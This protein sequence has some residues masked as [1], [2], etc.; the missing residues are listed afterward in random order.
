M[1]SFFHINL[2]CS[3]IQLNTH[4]TPD[5]HHTSKSACLVNRQIHMAHHT[6]ISHECTFPI[7]Y[8]RHILNHHA[9]VQFWSNSWYG[10]TTWIYYKAKIARI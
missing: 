9:S 10:N 3:L 1:S 7:K 4:S 6:N 8:M 2:L 5:K